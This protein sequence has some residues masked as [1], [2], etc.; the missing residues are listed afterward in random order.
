L[1]VLIALE[2]VSRE[3]DGGRVVALDDVSLAIEKGQSVAVVGTSGSGKTTLIMLMCGIMAP[4]G[5]TIRWNGAPVASVEEWATLRRSEIGIVFQDFNLFPTLSA[6]ENV[7]VATFGTGIDSRERKRRAE[8][9]LDAVGLTARSTH[10]PHQ[11]SGGERQRVAIARSIVNR[12]AVILADE[13]T[14]NLDS[15]NGAAIMDL[16]FDLH[17]TRGVTLVLVTHDA[18]VADRCARQVRI[19]DGR[20]IELGRPKLSEAAS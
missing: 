19:K 5:G 16:L 17:W 7:E 4:S 3:F 6:N 2:H 11:L 1:A 13:P 12:P 15:V 9:A 8:A 20:L 10:L 14:G 18:H